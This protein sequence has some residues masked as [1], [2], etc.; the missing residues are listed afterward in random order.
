MKNAKIEYLD[1][2]YNPDK[3]VVT[4]EPVKTEAK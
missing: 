1:E 2:K 3:K 4:P